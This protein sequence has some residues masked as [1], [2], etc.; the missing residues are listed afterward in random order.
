MAAEHHRASLR[1]GRESKLGQLDSGAG[2]VDR[3]SGAIVLVEEASQPRQLVYERPALA[4]GASRYVPGN[5]IEVGHHAP[6]K[7]L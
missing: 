6:P 5:G 4:D 2:E 3:G 1:A 7:E